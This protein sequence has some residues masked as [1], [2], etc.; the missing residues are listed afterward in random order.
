MTI[1][2]ASANEY[3]ASNFLRKDEW[4]LIPEDD[5]ESLLAT[6]EEDIIAYLMA[7]EVDPDSYAETAPFT[8]FQKAIFEWAL[9]LYTNKTA[10]RSAT[11]KI[12]TGAIKIKVYEVG[13]EQYPE[14]SAS[15]RLDSYNY[16]ISTSPAARFLR[17]IPKDVR[18]IR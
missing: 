18:I 1:T 12:V 15:K 5:L 4:G 11:N 14:A 16:M 3:F 2:V 9:F 13:E 7:N 8:P 6:A 17:A 10:I